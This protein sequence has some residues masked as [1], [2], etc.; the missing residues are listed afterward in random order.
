MRSQVRFCIL[1]VTVVTM[2]LLLTAGCAAP[3][4]PAPEATTAAPATATAAITPEDVIP[5][6][7]DVVMGMQADID[8]LDP[9]NWTGFFY[10]TQ[11]MPNIYDMLLTRD[12]AT[13]EIG[14]GL[15]ERWEVSE[16]GMSITLYLKEGVKFHDGAPMDAN[17]LDYAFERI[18]DENTQPNV[19]TSY[20]EPVQDWEVVDDYTFKIN[21]KYPSGVFL[22]SLT[23]PQ[24]SVVCKSA[25]EEWGD[26]FGQHPC[27]TGPFVFKEWV[28]DDHITLVRN[29]DYNWPPPYFSH[30]GQA[31]LDSVTYRIIPDQITRQ[32][33]I[34]TGELNMTMYPQNREVPRMIE[35]PGFEAYPVP[36]QGMPRELTLPVD[37]WPFDDVRVR[38]AMAYAL[39]RQ[40]ILD[41]VFEGVGLVTS[42]FLAPGTPCYWEGAEASGI[43]YS[44]DLDEANRL[45][46]EAGWEPGADGILVKDGQRFHVTMSGF[47]TPLFMTLHQVVQAQL[48]EV[49]I[50]VEIVALE[51]AAWMA[52]LRQA[53][54]NFSDNQLGP[55]SDPHVMFQA[56]DSAQIY[57]T[58]WNA[59]F[60]NN[61]EIDSLL[62]E[63]LRTMDQS[64]RC[65]I[66]KEI[67]EI[68]MEDL[69]YV[70]F[71]AQVDY[72]IT[73]SD[74]NGLLF[75]PKSLPLFYD[76]YIA[77]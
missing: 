77:E 60:Y 51:Q 48:A 74:V 21:L 13:G 38:K 16:D 43:G 75:D 57:P 7:G 28:R 41:V 59:A 19:R 11:I 24:L 73:S 36:R 26:D 20:A 55:G 52:A 76:V 25:V 12:P 3:E 39:D 42:S 68:V 61:P 1:S 14:P 72:F 64:E 9:H 22:D 50:E 6:G 70:P 4:T 8:A 65:G 71:Y 49:G 15:A 62:G 58:G 46:A 5:Q 31:Y 54:C 27:G 32:A 44:H 69:P 17:D 37:R 33:A 30:T 18:F 35:D 40:E 47:Q 56:L 29:P 45:L 10:A 67:Q 63:A 34:E 23:Y 2:L 53:E 66:Y